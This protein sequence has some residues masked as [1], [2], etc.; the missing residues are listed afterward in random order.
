M[1]NEINK[2]NTTINILN[3]LI[4]KDNFDDIWLLNQLIIKCKLL[5]SH[6]KEIENINI[7]KIVTQIE[8]EADYFIKKYPVSQI[9]ST[10]LL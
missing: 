9:N 7:T 6:L 8:K 2:I 1:K 5:L 3:A 4:I 10:Q